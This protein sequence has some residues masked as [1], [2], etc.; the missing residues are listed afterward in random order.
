MRSDKNL[1]K[2]GKAKVHYCPTGDLRS[3][4]KQSWTAWP[5]NIVPIG[6]RE[7]SVWKYQSTLCKIAKERRSHVHRSGSLISHTV[8]DTL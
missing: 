8:S 6:C 2:N 4:I 3:G 1:V 5:L 7:T